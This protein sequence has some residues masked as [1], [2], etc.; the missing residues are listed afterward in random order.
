MSEKNDHDGDSGGR[1]RRAIEPEEPYEDLFGVRPTADEIPA[2]EPEYSIDWGS[3]DPGAD[4][5]PDA[6]SYVY[7]RA[8]YELPD[9]PLEGDSE[10]SAKRI[11]G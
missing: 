1:E 7:Y 4:P 10:W 3:D 5:S 8:T 6:V 2:G 11:G 9:E